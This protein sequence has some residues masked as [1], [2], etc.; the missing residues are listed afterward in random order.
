MSTQEERIVLGLDLGTNSIGWSLL[1][2]KNK[3]PMEIVDCGS[4]IFEAG[5]EGDIAAGRGESRAAGRREAR[6]VRRQTDRRSRRRK[7]IFRL[8]QRIHLLPEGK[9]EDIIPSLDRQWIQQYH[10]QL[11][12]SN[13][14]TLA[15][16]LPY[17]LRKRALDHSLQAEELG[18]ALYHLC[19]RRGFL[20]NRKS[21]IKDKEEEGKVKA[22]I[23]DLRKRMKQAGSRTLGEYFASLNPHE[24]RIR[25]QWTHRSMYTDEFDA[26]WQVQKEYHPDILT[27]ENYRCLR[28][29]F[30]FQRPLK[31]A[32]GLVGRCDAEP[33]QRRAPWA[34]WEA[35][36]FRLLQMVNNCRLITEDGE[37]RPFTEEEYRLLVDT[38]EKEGDLKFTEAKK[39]LG[40]KRT[41][42][43]TLQAGDETRFVGNRI[44]SAM[45]LVFGNHWNTFDDEKKENILEDLRSFTNSEA[46]K[47]RAIRAWGLN[48]DAAERFAQM[49][50][51]P[52]YCN[53]SR[54]AIRKLLPHL[55][56]RLTY[57]E[58]RMETYGKPNHLS[59]ELLNA[60]PPIDQFMDL[61]NPTVHRVLTELRHLV[62]TVI[63]HHG[64]PDII[65]VELA[66]EMKQTNQ[67]R[68]QTTKRMRAN[69]AARVKA[70]TRICKEARL[71]NPRPDDIL[72]VLLADECDWMCPY[73]GEK[74]NMKNLLG[75]ESKFD[76]EHIIPF[77]RCLDDSF[78]NKT[79]CHNETNRNVK[80]NNGPWEVWHTRPE[81]EEIVQR[82]QSFKGDFKEIKLK[83][84]QMT[85][86][87]IQELADDFV[88]RQMNDTRYASRLAMQYLACLYGGLHDADGI[89]RVQAVKG[90]TTKYL[91]DV[92]NLNRVL[93][94]GGTKNRDDHRH[95]AVDAIVIALTTPG[96]VKMLTESALPAWERPRYKGRF[97]VPDMPWETFEE[98]VKKAIDSIVVSH[99]VKRSING[100]LHKDTNYA[101][102]KTEPGVFHL[103]RLL[104]SL[105]GSEV[106][107]IVDPRIR[108][109][110]QEKI[111][112]LGTTDPSKAFSESSNHPYLISKKKE[113]EKKIPIH[114]V[115]I[116][117]KDN[118]QAYGRDKHRQRY[119]LTASNHHIEIVAVLDEEGNE[120]QWEGHV[121]STFEAM[122]RLAKEKKPGAKRNRARTQPSE[123]Q[124]INAVQ[125]EHGPNRR[126][127]F[128]IAPGDTLELRNP[129][130][131]PQYIVIR[132]VSTGQNNTF[133]V[134]GVS[135]TD[136][137]KIAD[138]KASKELY[139]IRS[140]K[141]MKSLSPHKVNVL[142][143]GKIIYAND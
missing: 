117:V 85:T 30:F 114:K 55:E 103:R 135:L 124:T 59:Q 141:N 142:P 109:A 64:R 34:C 8:L 19:Q 71:P 140:M 62:N 35:Q 110:V 12:A 20:S 102:V 113:K 50:L 43:F 36:R 58:A 24:R 65:R 122:Q 51:E 57:M 15:N 28:K 1:R 18:R 126:F 5:M 17:W 37:E 137:R 123:S 92:W 118:P 39:L 32:K 138:L 75:S 44:T 56:N 86:Q 130:Q 136:A 33:G 100:P 112:E 25:T 82:V 68:Q 89:R 74:I 94:D 127:L 88:D 101:P 52:D 10:A 93:G 125:R 120:T 111:Q 13:E 7:K 26:I 60:L 38:L 31:S 83:R 105:K 48:N 41:A 9:P 22:G 115:R 104:S 29:A 63:A 134:S 66:R 49:E 27:D 119:C 46:L 11:N 133:E 90:G 98:D 116:K 95:H 81:W 4:R 23:S 14:V 96:S 87:D 106:A 108:K 131:W 97:H 53:L 67:Q 91:R 3:N 77:S 121:V 70:V 76:I 45:I 72:R 69:E 40:R 47:Q 21:P 143:D 79:L 99:R 128:S 16:Y 54:K 132:T 61:R 78:S 42:K 107:S 80:R 6:L 84:F 139:R 73:T 129:G 2:F